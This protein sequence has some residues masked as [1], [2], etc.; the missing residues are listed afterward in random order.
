[1]KTFRDLKTKILRDG[2][3]QKQKISNWELLTLNQIEDKKNLVSGFIS[4]NAYLCSL[5]YDFKNP[6][7]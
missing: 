4:T 6:I 1:M 2:I 7:T 3:Q 5:N